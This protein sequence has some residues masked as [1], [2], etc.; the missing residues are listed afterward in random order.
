MD[1]G[2]ASLVEYTDSGNPATVKIM[3][4]KKDEF[5][6]FLS[7]DFKK[8]RDNFTPVDN[9]KYMNQEEVEDREKQA[10]AAATSTARNKAEVGNRID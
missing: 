1:V 9:R 8:L 4:L 3:K 7:D 5:D 6:W 10:A 2:Y